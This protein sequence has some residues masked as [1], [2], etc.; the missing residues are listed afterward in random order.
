MNTDPNGTGTDGSARGPADNAT[1]RPE[2]L[3]VSAPPADAESIAAP[4]RADGPDEEK[5]SENAARASANASATARRRPAARPPK[6]ASVV[7][8]VERAYGDPGRKVR[9]PR[10]ELAALVLTS[11]ADAM[12]TQW[13]SDLVRK[14][15]LLK[16]PPGLL[17]AAAALK[18]NEPV[19]Q[20]LVALTHR[21]LA[22]HPIFRHYVAVPAGTDSDQPASG[23]SARVSDAAQKLT[24]DDLG[25][26]SSAY[27]SP[28]RELLRNNAVTSFALLWVLDGL[29]T[30]ARFIA[31]MTETVWSRPV[32]EAV[33]SAD[34]A[35]ALVAADEKRAL[36]HLVG[37]FMVDRR[38]LVAQ[39]A[40]A[41]D[42]RAADQ[43]RADRSESENLAL[44][45]AVVS[46]QARCKS[47]ADRV[48]D[49][50]SEIEAERTS[51]FVDNS[52]MTDDY[53]GLRTRVIRRLSSQVEM[54]SDGLHALRNGSTPVAEEF[55]DRALTA[56]QQEVKT[57]KELGG[58]R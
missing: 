25:I 26:E 31:E 4:P 46:E 50:T 20:A 12:D 27:R 43:Q 49:L 21:A 7:E 55:I 8:L 33:S 39:L 22:L 11:G 40:Q 37:H 15:P 48:A 51:R 30:S 29:W 17:T 54:L 14:D 56:I 58:T 53:E 32:A 9:L 24:P 44:R 34:I 42:E 28:Q 6:P 18:P 57:L 47:L 5:P 35:A 23:T 41:K 36:D 45:D 2:S 38:K 1:S 16:V 10:S 19:R 13:L 3:D 52:H